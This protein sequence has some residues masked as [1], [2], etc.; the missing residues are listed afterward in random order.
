MIWSHA[1]A[2]RKWMNC[3]LKIW[4]SNK[5]NKHDTNIKQRLE[6]LGVCRG[7]PLVQAEW[8]WMH[9][10]TCAGCMLQRSVTALLAFAHTSRSCGLQMSMNLIV[11]TV[12]WI[13]AEYSAKSFGSGWWTSPAAAE[14]AN[15]TWHFFGLFELCHPRM[16]VILENDS[17]CLK[18]WLFFI[19][20]NTK[21]A[22]LIKGNG[23]IVFSCGPQPWGFGLSSGCWQ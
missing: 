6:D 11:A 13:L 2:C 10:R 1:V 19:W 16:V 14:G 21:Q 9:L 5:I 18:L 8:C 12:G 15:Q 7:R 17:W 23:G 20:T 22:L 4:E 3:I